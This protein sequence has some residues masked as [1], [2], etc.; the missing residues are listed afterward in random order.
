MRIGIYGGSFNP[1]HNMHLKMATELLD[2]KLVDKVIFVPTGCKYPKVGLANDIKRLEMIKLMVK[3]FSN[4]EVSDYELKQDLVYTYQ[5][6]GY[7]K[8]LYCDDEICFI[9]GSDLLKEFNTWDN[10]SYIL[11]NFKVLVTLRNN[12]K[13]KDLKR[14]SFPYSENIIYTNVNLNELCSTEIRKAIH[15]NDFCFLREN[16]NLD[17]LD[18]IRKKELYKY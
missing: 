13:V 1:P 18:Y 16:M 7:F 12:D 3:D 5:T 11:E 8:Q 15:E 9:L 2:K 14:I 6:L 17:V 4:I 10:C